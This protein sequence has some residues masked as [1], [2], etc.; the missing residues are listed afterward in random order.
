MNR[1]ARGWAGRLL[2]VLVVSVAMIGPAIAVHAGTVGSTRAA[3][4]SPSAK[5]ATVRV[6]AMAGIGATMQPMST[7]YVY[8]TN[9]GKKYHRAG[10]RYLKKSKIKKT[11]KWVKS[12]GYTACKVC[13]PPK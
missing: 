5:A 10:C 11:L 12:H 2:L 3:V 1:I 13:K 8:I 9:T 6:A 7:T 4:H